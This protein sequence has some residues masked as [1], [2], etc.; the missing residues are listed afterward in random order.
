MTRR[1]R[2][3][4]LVMAGWSFCAALIAARS[5][6]AGAPLLLVNETHSVPA[7]LYRRATAAPLQVGSLVVLSPPPAAK[8][9]LAGLGAAPDLRLLKRVAAL[10]GQRV[11]GTDGRLLTPSRMVDVPERDR[12]GVRLR[13]WNACRRLRSDELF[14]LGD[15]PTSFDS[16]YFGPVPLASIEAIYREVLTW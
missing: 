16:R 8:T 3:P 6:S 9:Y 4:Y 10:R 2:V 11:C 5:D 14:V 15:S 7:G 1:P 12:R 13:A